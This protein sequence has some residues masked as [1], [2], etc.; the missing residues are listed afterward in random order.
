[1]SRHGI[2]KNQRTHVH[3]GGGGET[4]NVLN[5]SNGKKSGYKSTCMITLNFATPVV[6]S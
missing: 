5:R 2:G 4:F 6:Q 1:M 3:G